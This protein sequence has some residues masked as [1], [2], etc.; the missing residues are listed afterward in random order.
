M[1]RRLLGFTA[2]VILTALGAMGSVAQAAVPGVDGQTCMSGGG[3]VEYDSDTGRWICVDG[4]YN[5]E[6][7]S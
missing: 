2:A 1:R 6:P 3:T 7:I 5:D 4:K